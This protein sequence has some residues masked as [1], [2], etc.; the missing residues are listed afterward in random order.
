MSTNVCP[1]GGTSRGV[2]RVVRH[3]RPKVLAA[4]DPKLRRAYIELAGCISEL[5]LW[6]F[7]AARLNASNTRKP[8]WGI[9]SEERHP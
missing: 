5:S 9:F 4:Y 6:V 3:T 8:R 2:P 7:L 1:V